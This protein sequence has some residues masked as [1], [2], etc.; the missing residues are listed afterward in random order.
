MFP[1][2]TAAQR[3]DPSIRAWPGRAL[4]LRVVVDPDANN[5]EPHSLPRVRI[6]LVIHPRPNG[7]ED[8]GP[9]NGNAVGSDETDN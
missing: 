5:A 2:R 4:S 6:F 7:A 3:Q 9:A 1:L 8:P